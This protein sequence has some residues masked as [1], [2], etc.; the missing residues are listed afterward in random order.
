V[1][2]DL[3]TADIVSVAEQKQVVARTE[4]DPKSGLE[5]DPDLFALLARGDDVG[6][7]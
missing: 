7:E 4:V 5:L 3:S 6:R 1:G 2:T